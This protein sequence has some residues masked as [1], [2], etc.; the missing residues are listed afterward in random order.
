MINWNKLQVEIDDQARLQLD[1]YFR[2]L[3]MI[4]DD[5]KLSY[6]KDEVFQELEN[7]IIDYIR[8]QEIIVIN[9]NT[10]LKIIAELGPPDE[11]TDY[12]N[13]S[14]LLE[15]IEQ[16]TPSTLVINPKDTGNLLLCEYC[17]SKNEP[18]SIYCIDCG[19][20]MRNDL[21]NDSKNY[22][23]PI[24]YLFRTNIAYFLSMTTILVIG[25][26]IFW[27]PLNIADNTLYNILILFLVINEVLVVP[28]L[29][30][31]KFIKKNSIRYDIIVFLT[32]YITKFSF[33]VFLYLI[34]TFF[35]N[36]SFWSISILS[37]IISIV[38][39]ISTTKLLF[40]ST[41]TEKVGRSLNVQLNFI[42]R[43]IYPLEIIIILLMYVTTM[44]RSDLTESQA[45]YTLTL[46]FVIFIF[47]PLMDFSLYYLL[48]YFKN[49]NS[50]VFNQ[51]IFSIN[52]INSKNID[53]LH[54][55]EMFLFICIIIIIDS[56]IFLTKLTFDNETVHLMFSV[57]V[58][59]FV[60][61]NLFELYTNNT[62]IF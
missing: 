23:N 30:I 31:V 21:K 25:I 3:E 43:A 47:V 2:D 37:L 54:T 45:N 62:L 1:H 12:S 52:K 50:I 39:I 13:L 58:L 14:S 20:K 29:F 61:Y 17:N 53:N 46:I 36:D 18:D 33:L 60:L 49:K 11:Y 19:R 22:S 7:Y 16:K 26:S 8:N 51:P 40:Y 56:T 32:S 9:F 59:F 15:K 48:P 34:G 10:A 42:G 55:L 28:G 41:L 5:Q 35:S 4:L 24:F 38:L 6:K 57:F 44:F 27:A